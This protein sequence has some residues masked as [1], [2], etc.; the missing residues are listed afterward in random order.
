M[1][2]KERTKAFFKFTDNKGEKKT[3]LCQ[4]IDLGCLR[5]V[6]ASEWTINNM[7]NLERFVKMS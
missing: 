5:L 2:E 7:T 3:L 6:K 4:A 1:T